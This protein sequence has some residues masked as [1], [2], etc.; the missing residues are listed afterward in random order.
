MYFLVFLS[1]KSLALL[2]LSLCHLY[3]LTCRKKEEKKLKAQIALNTEFL[4]VCRFKSPA[5]GVLFANITAVKVGFWRAS[6]ICHVCSNCLPI[7]FPSCVA[8]PRGRRECL[9]LVVFQHLL[10]PLTLTQRLRWCWLAALRRLS[11]P[12]FIYAC[13][14]ERMSGDISVSPTTVIVMDVFCFA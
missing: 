2:Q 6:N 8:W 3:W 4:R 5:S 9:M 10:W 11:A 14:W 1:F 7:C 12:L 13:A